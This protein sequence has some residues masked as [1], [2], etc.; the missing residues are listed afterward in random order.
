MCCVSVQPATRSPADWLEDMAW[1]RRMYRQSRFRWVPE[2]PL[3]IAL[4]WTRGRLEH[5]TLAHLH[6]LDGQIGDLRSFADGIDDA[7]TPLLRQARRHSEVGEW[8]QGLELVGLSAVGADD[9][10]QRTARPGGADHPDARRAL[11]GFPLP[12]PWSQVWE[13]RQVRSMYAA[14]Q[15][16]MEDVFCDLVLELHPTYG[17]R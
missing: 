9:L 3:G 7:M 5:E 17:W 8:T 10:C 4:T 15:A 16:I 1:H 6:T 2:D 14:A 12:N 11:R 13:L